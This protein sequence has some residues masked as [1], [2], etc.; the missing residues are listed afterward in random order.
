VKYGTENLNSIA[1]LTQGIGAIVGACMAQMF[2][3]AKS[4]NPF[5]C[6]GVYILLV[7]IYFVFAMQLDR[8]LEPL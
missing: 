3:T 5:E 8:S 2:S 7:G 4:V 6:F 1:F